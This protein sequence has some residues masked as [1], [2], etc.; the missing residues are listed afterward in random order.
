MFFSIR[1]NISEKSFFYI[2]R[3]VVIEKKVLN[4]DLKMPKKPLAACGFEKP[5]F[6]HDF[7]K[8]M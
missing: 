8:L 6:W 1:N 2:Q 7:S 3:I 4:R 5:Y